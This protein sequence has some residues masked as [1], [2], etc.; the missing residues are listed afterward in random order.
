M[1][2]YQKEFENRI[3]FIREILKKWAYEHYPDRE[4]AFAC[5]TA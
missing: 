2:D 1:Q 3:S 4:A 5:L